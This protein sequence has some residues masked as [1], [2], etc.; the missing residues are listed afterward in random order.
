MKNR[1][2]NCEGKKSHGKRY[3]ESV[4]NQQRVKLTFINNINRRH[5]LKNFSNFEN[6][7]SIYKIEIV[8]YFLKI[9]SKRKL[10]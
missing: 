4:S 1:S 3:G 9:T 7:F 8:T 5:I 6:F 2:K 10:F